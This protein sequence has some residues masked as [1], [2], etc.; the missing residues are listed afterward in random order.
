MVPAPGCCYTLSSTSLQVRVQGVEG[1]LQR[2]AQQA[3]L[4]QP[5][6]ECSV[7]EVKETAAAVFGTGFFTSCGTKARDTEDGTEIIIQA[8]S[9]TLQAAFM[10]NL[11]ISGLV[12]HILQSA[13][14]PAP[15]KVVPCRSTHAHG[16][17]HTAHGTWK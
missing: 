10:R 11:Q 16:A 14:A 17:W 9:V 1:P 5:G 3:V 8:R 15:D 12:H 13:Q 6:Q 2:M 4:L 7:Q